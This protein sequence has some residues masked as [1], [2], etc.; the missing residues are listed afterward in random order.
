MHLQMVMVITDEPWATGNRDWPGCSLHDAYSLLNPFKVK[1]GLQSH[2][3]FQFQLPLSLLNPP[4][5]AS[6]ERRGVGGVGV[7]F[8][9]GNREHRA[10]LQSHIAMVIKQGHNPRPYASSRLTGCRCRHRHRVGDVDASRCPLCVCRCMH[11]CGFG[12]RM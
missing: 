6:E 7:G 3:Q 4:K 2:F 10:I 8:G 5:R 12:C 9:N 1:K 11:R